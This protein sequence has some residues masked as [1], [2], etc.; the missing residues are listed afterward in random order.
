M[1]MNQTNSKLQEDMRYGQRVM[2]VTT[3][4][5]DMKGNVDCT[6]GVLNI[7]YRRRR[8]KMN[9]YSEISIRNNRASGAKTERQKI[10][11]G[12]CKSQLFIFE[13]LDGW[14]VCTY[15]DVLQA[16][17]LD[18]GYV[19]PNNDGITSA[20]YIPFKKIKHLMTEKK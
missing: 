5:A 20:Y 14:V 8:F 4:D 11:D 2:I 3:P 1:G 19:K 7:A 18:I 10:L 16:L 15:S 12:E 13:F 17:R 6:I 9:K